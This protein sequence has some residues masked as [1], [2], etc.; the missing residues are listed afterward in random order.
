MRTR[1]TTPLVYLVALVIAGITV[2]PIVY[3]AIGGFRTTGQLAAEPLA[4]PDPWVPGNYTEV[5]RTGT[6]WGQV[7][8]SLI[9][10][11]VSTLLC[12]GTGAMAAFALSRMAFR[13]RDALYGF[14]V[15]GLLFPAAVAILPL[16][17]LLRNL[18]FTGLLAVALP[19][20]AFSLSM[21]VVILRP[22]MRA[23][24]AELEDAAII[25]GCGRLGFFWRIL[26]PLSRPA[27]VTV[28]VLAVV[29]SWNDYL[30]PLLVISDPAE[31][32]L[33]LGTAV[34]SSAH[35]RDTAGIL[36]FTTLSMLPALLFFVVME[37]RLVGGLAGSVKG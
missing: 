20:A 36:A 5:A 12:V 1:V 11:T 9:V 15:L 3:V 10:A 17:L 25:D 19:Q 8:N 22:F 4:W 16:F 28:S 24:P 37:R 13:G 18:G 29:K 27:L 30:L 2:A 32:T 6:F 35:G 34:F 31:Y 23:V 7:A 14:F 26:L 21:T 33:P